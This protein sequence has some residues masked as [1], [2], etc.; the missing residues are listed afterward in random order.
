MTVQAQPLRKRSGGRWQKVR[1]RVLARDGNRCVQCGSTERLQVDHIVE[2]QDQVDDSIHNLQTLCHACHTAKTSA[3]RR[4]RA[5]GKTITKSDRASMGGSG[6]PG[7]QFPFVPERASTTQGISSTAVPFSAE[8]RRMGADDNAPLIFPDPHPDAVESLGDRAARDIEERLRSDPWVRAES[9]RWWQWLVL[10]RFLERRA[11]GS[12]C[13]PLG[14]V[15]VARQQG[16]TELLC[17]LAAW[18]CG[19]PDLF[20]GTPQLVAHSANT[21]VMSR[22]MQMTRM[23]WAEARGYNIARHLG[24]S[25]IQWP[26]GSTWQTMA[27]ENM[28]GRSLDLIVADE[29]W[30]WSAED[31]WQATFPTIAERPGAQC[32][33]FSAA[34]DEP[35]TLV[36]ELLNNPPAGAAVMVWAAPEDADESAAAT[37]R[38]ATPHYDHRRSQQMRMAYGQASF[39]TQWLNIWRSIG[40]AGTWLQLGK[41]DAART[42]LDIPD[43]PQVA[44]VE[45]GH[46]GDGATVALAWHDGQRCCVTAYHVHDLAAAWRHVA[47]ARRVLCGITLLREPE[48]RAL[49]AA[50]VGVKETPGALSELRRLIHDG[51]LAWDGDQL[52]EQMRRAKISEPMEGKLKVL[53]GAPSALV[54]CAAWAVQQVRD[55]PEPTLV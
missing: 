49:N 38:A 4:A 11:D 3:L 23:R 9:L 1:A 5:N 13:W 6:T 35:R 29:V 39:A 17:E 40:T 22:Q 51:S 55:D 42:S 15:S 7:P 12:W 52:A 26:D 44:V 16:K 18:R 50:G 20:G 21:V 33:L 54:R 24:S 53:T 47:R 41:W 25:H 28:Y 36:P 30:S 34:H 8:P 43:T 2:A 14:F 46:G 37:W 32:L 31:F 19:N 48:A 45:D 27:A 10:Q